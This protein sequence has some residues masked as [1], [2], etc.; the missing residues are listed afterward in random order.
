VDGGGCVPI[1]D[2]RIPSNILDSDLTEEQ[3]EQA[4]VTVSRGARDVE[5]LALL[6]DMLGL[7]PKEEDATNDAREIKE[8]KTAELKAIRKAARRAKREQEVAWLQR[9]DY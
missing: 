4:R 1:R 9:N 7:L 5:D 8:R 2:G 3:I 6:L